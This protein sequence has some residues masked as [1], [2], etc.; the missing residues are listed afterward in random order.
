LKQHTT[1]STPNGTSNGTTN[2]N[3]ALAR[4]NILPLIININIIFKEIKK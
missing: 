2:G 4:G 3:A 1:E